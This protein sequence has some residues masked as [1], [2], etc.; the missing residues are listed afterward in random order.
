[1]EWHEAS[2]QRCVYGLQIWAEGQRRYQSEPWQGME[3][4]DVGR[5]PE[6]VPKQAMGRAW[7]LTRCSP[8]IF[9]K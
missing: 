1:M 6:E 2:V 7:R 8:N 5:G 9:S 4:A 3:A